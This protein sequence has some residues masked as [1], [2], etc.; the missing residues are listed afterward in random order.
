[1]E[2]KRDIETIKVINSDAKEMLN[3]IKQH[4]TAKLTFITDS[5][6]AE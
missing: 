6:Y 5:L 2:L 3:D 1:M 4:S